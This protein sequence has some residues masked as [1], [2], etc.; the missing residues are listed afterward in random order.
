MYLYIL[1]V[2]VAETYIYSM[3]MELESHDGMEIDLAA[4]QRSW[5]DEK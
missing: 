3:K 2:A 4:D 1:Q 5:R